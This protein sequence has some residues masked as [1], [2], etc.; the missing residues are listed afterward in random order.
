MKSNTADLKVIPFKLY[1]DHSRIRKSQEV[2]E[3]IQPCHTILLTW[4]RK[5]PRN[6]NIHENIHVTYMVTLFVEERT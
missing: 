5:H 6:E 4:T 2:R 3:K 1:L